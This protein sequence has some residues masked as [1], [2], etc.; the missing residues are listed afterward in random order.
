MFGGCFGDA[1]GLFEGCLG[2]V[3]QAIPPQT[4]AFQST[5]R[6]TNTPAYDREGPTPNKSRKRNAGSL[7]L[8]YPK[9]R[10]TSIDMKTHLWMMVRAD[11]G[12]GGDT[13]PC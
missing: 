6:R 13:S 5:E 12:R 8:C 3:L 11:R 10:A 2:I 9:A 1:R 4:I 7:G